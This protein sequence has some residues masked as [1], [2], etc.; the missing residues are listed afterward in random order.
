MWP[1]AGSPSLKTL[2]GE[3]W[4]S[5]PKAHGLMSFSVSF[6]IHLSGTGNLQSHRPSTE[7]VVGRAQYPVVKNL[8][9]FTAFISP[10]PMLTLLKHG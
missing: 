8:K 2:E 7:D 9:M 6:G 5:L 10:L 3:G 1:D 4:G